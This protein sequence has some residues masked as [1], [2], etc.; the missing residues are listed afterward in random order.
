MMSKVFTMEMDI[1]GRGKFITTVITVTEVE[2]E[3]IM[4]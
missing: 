2:I 4:S 3:K 1:C